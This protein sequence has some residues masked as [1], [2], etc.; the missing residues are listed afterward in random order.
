MEV[1]EESAEGVNN[2]CDGIKDWCGLKEK[3]LDVASEVC[4]YTKG[5]GWRNKDVDAYGLCVKRG[6]YLGFE[7]S[8]RKRKIK[9]NILR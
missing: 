5:M 8:V 7:N 3:L 2:K 1:K 9:R 4:S 6:S